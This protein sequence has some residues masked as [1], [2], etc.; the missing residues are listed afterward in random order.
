M[1]GYIF[2]IIV[3]WIMKNVTEGNNTG[4][5]WKFTSKLE[6]LEFA[7]DIALF[8]SN[9]Q[10]MQSKVSKLNEFTAKTRLKINTKKTEVVRQNSKSNSRIVIDGHQLNEVDQFTYLGA[11]VSK[12]G[13]AEDDSMNNIIHKA[14]VSFIKLKKMWNSS[15]F[16]L[17]TKLR[18]FKSLVLPVLLYGCETWK[19][20]EHYKKRMDTFQFKVCSCGIWNT[21]EIVE[22]CKGR[23]VCG[24]V[25]N[26][27]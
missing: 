22:S 23:F 16:A 1:S 19:I 26:E 14:R 18:L 9:I 2:L 15:K 13:G 8:S 12:Q 3:D 27:G 6:D 24:I 10:H 4:I 25:F 11:N 5:R 20:N 7:D 21:S 17:R